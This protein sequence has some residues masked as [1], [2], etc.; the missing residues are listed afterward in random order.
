MYFDIAMPITLFAVTLVSMLCNEKV[1]V[2][3][4][5]LFAE[6]A[7]T[8]K[9]IIMLVT[10]TAL[11][12]SFIVFIPQSAII[13]VFLFSYSMLLFMFTYTFSNKG[14]YIAILTPIAF[15]LLYILFHDTP[16]W[17][18]YLVNIFAVIFTV[19]I[20]L[21]LGSL[22]T[23]K[24][25][26]FFSVALTVLDV[27]LV[28]VTGTMISAATTAVS[29]NLPVVVTLPIIPTFNGK[30]LL[31][32]GDLLFAGV[33]AIQTSKKFSKNFAI[34]TT[35]AM[36]FSFFIFETILLTYRPGPFPGTV[37]IICG[38]LPLTFWRNRTLK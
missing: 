4:K 36:T 6:R 22:F 24:T 38:W 37:M 11:V 35:A 18:E 26:V 33:L 32:V 28:L 9:D 14:W 10:L 12:T 23:W 29:L 27:I 31:G 34:L 30:M 1:E 17:S 8:L 3:L 7:F 2:K 15:I 5:S 21:Y 19:L 20:S 25:T 13:T 16:L